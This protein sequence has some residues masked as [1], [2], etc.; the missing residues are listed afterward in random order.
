MTCPSDAMPELH[1]YVQECARAD[2]QIEK[3]HNRKLSLLKQ[4]QSLVHR[5]QLPVVVICNGEAFIIKTSI[6]EPDRH[7]HPPVHVHRAGALVQ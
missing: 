6:A 7:E 1:N 5:D 3:L 4:I 2:E